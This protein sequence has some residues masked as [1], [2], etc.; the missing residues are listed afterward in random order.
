[1]RTEVVVDPGPAATVSVRIRC[2]QVQHRSIEA[3]T[4]SADS[5]EPVE[6][7]DVD[8]VRWVDW[9]EA[10]E[11]EIDLPPFDVLPVAG[12][13]HGPCR[14]HCRTAE[15]IELLTAAR[16]EVVGPGGANVA[17]RRRCGDE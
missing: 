16:G 5:F 15:H 8:G 10:V 1:M 7:L 4:A 2:L 11:H 12:A 13:G 17:R 6:F 3:A 14:S 9:D